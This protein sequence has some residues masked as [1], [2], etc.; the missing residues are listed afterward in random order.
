MNDAN[1]DKL[2]RSV[3]PDVFLVKK[4]YGEKS[5]RRRAR[6]WKLKHMA[7]ELH[8]GLSSTNE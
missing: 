4:F 1:F 5:A 6:A 8:E 2:D 7:E 3:I